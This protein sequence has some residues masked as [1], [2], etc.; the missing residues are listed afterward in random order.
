MSTTEAA[1]QA[2]RSH[3]R[4]G[5]GSRGP[6]LTVRGREGRGSRGHG[7]TVRGSKGRGRLAHARAA[8]DRAT[9]PVGSARAPQVRVDTGPAP[10]PVASARA[11]HDRLV[12]TVARSGVPATGSGPSGAT[13]SPP[14]RGRDGR[15]RPVELPEPGRVPAMSS[16]LATSKVR[17]TGALGLTRAARGLILVSARVGAQMSIPVGQ[18]ASAGS[19][20]H[21]AP[22][23]DSGPANLTRYGNDPAGPVCPTRASECRRPRPVKCCRASRSLLPRTAGPI[24]A[25]KPVSP[26]QV[27]P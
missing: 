24:R 7:P 17:L 14:M 20:V 10:G 25:P 15:P 16:V 23:S 27:P 21:T 22:V 26:R 1:S 18:P 12:Q 11:D 4:E 9:G 6:A 19:N 5:R 13:G 2:G 3:G 8:R